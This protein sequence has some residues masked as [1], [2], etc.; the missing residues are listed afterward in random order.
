MA[1]EMVKYE[2]K[3]AVLVDRF[4]VLSNACVILRGLNTFADT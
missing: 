1:R 4:G 3:H 2:V